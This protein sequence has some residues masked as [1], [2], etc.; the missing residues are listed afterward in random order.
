[1]VFP[2]CWNRISRGIVVMEVSGEMLVDAM[3]IFIFGF[4]LV[5][6]SAKQFSWVDPI[7][8]GQSGPHSDQAPTLSLSYF[9]YFHPS[10]TILLYPCSHTRIQLTHSL[11][12]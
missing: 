4:F 6:F 5:A 1:M 2:G 11:S 8:D 10:S 12:S 3:I 7:I 9:I